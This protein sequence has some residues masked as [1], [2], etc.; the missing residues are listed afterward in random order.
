MEDFMCGRVNNLRQ[1]SSPQLSHNDS[2]RAWGITKSHM[3]QG[4]DNR[5]AKELSWCLSLSNSLWQWWSCGLVYCPGGNATDQI[6]RMPASSD[7]ISSWTPL[8]PQHSNPN[9]GVLT[10]SHTSHHPSQ[11]PCLR[12]I[13]YAT[14]KL[15]HDSSKM[16]QKQSEGFHTFL[17]HFFQV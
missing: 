1:V 3:E 14:Q 2:L 13:S 4:L 5:E 7:G 9:T 11:T 16:L 12:W 17:L 8:T 10:S 15:K 6:W